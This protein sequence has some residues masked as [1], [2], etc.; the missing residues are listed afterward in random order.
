MAMGDM[1]QYKQEERYFKFFERGT[2]YD[3]EFF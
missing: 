1:V 3:F 2:R